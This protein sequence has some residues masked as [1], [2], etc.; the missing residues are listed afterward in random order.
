MENNC[1]ESFEVDD[2]VYVKQLQFKQKQN[3]WLTPGLIG[4]VKENDCETNNKSGFKR[5]KV[6]FSGYNKTVGL[7][8][9][10]LSK[11]SIK[12][13]YG[14]ELNLRRN[15]MNNNC[16]DFVE[17]FKV[18]TIRNINKKY[19]DEIESIKE[20]DKAF[21]EISKCKK[22]ISELLECDMDYLNFPEI[23]SQKTQDS[24][25]EINKKKL[26]D[27][28]KLNSLCNIVISTLEMC[29]NFEECCSVLINYGFMNGDYTVNEDFCLE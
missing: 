14:H 4:T 19:D 16:N 5:L 25:V 17:N 10:E 26:K 22:N 11:V 8:D 23:L 2:L 9:C 3:P 28:E 1:N 27:L 20:S 24:I 13:E 12:S 21:H 15:D 29:G 7:Y 6:F 18:L